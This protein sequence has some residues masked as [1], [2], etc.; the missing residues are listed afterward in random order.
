MTD[1]L[2]KIREQQQECPVKAFN[3]V[4][5]FGI[6]AY[7]TTK[8]T[9]DISGLIKRVEDDRY[10]ICV[11]ED[12]PVTRKR[13]TI[14]H[15]VAHYCLHKDDIGD[16]LIDDYLYRS[17]L[18]SAKEREANRLAGEILMPLHL[19]EEH[20]YKNKKAFELA[21]IFNVSEAAMSIRL[22]QLGIR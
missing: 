6:D 19:L 5:A 10:V 21:L 20:D 2:K 16:G 7:E 11:N 14:A 22:R 17:G 1:Y 12:H 4:N 8:F 9:N 3:I 13:F 15:E 18:S